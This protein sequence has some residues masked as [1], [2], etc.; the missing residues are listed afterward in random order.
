MIGANGVVG[1]SGQGGPA[2]AGNMNPMGGKGQ[3]KGKHQVNIAKAKYGVSG[4]TQQLNSMSVY[5]NDLVA[6]AHP[7]ESRRMAG[8]GS[9]GVGGSGFNSNTS[10]GNDLSSITKE[11]REMRTSSATAG[12]TN[13]E[14]TLLNNPIA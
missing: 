11:Q 13:T 10:T 6:E 1:I 14:F 7:R 5:Q 9:S 12:N 3:R 2:G 4:A 8:R